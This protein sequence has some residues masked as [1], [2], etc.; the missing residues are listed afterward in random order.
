M[1]IM[2]AGALQ[3]LRNMMMIEPERS[4]LREGVSRVGGSRRT[5]NYQASYRKA[6]SVHEDLAS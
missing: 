6:L 4:I 3:P 1:V 5:T 2:M